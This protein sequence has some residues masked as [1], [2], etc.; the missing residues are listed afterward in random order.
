MIEYH[1][2]MQQTTLLNGL[3][4]LEALA[5]S[6][7][8]RGVTEIAEELGIVKSNAHRLLQALAAKGYVRQDPGSARYACSLKIWGLATSVSERF[9]VA[10]VARPQLAELAR[11]TRETVH[12]SVLEDTEVVYLDKID[13]PQPVR[14][15][16]RVGGRAPAYCVA[17]GKAMLA[18]APREVLDHVCRKLKQHAPRTITERKALER[19]LLGV[20]N[21]GYAVNR[22]EWRESVGGIAAPI[23]GPAGQVVAAVGISGPV[24]RLSVSRLRKFAPQVIVAAGN[25]SRALGGVAAP[26]VPRVPRMPRMPRVPRAA[27]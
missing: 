2:N 4:L 24:E 8:P 19:E 5:A 10:V 18:F 17:T 12:L 22:G 26:R 27:G 21:A 13:S 6:R 9:D 16:S 11:R 15:Y 20:R 7:E 1:V 23:Y 14:A 25:I 3:R